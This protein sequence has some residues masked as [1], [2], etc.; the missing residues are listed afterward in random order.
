MADKC[1]KFI[2]HAVERETDVLE[3]FNADYKKGAF[4]ADQPEFRARVAAMLGWSYA[5]AMPAA[6]TST[7]VLEDAP[8]GRVKIRLV[9]S[10]LGAKTD[11]ERAKRVDRMIRDG[12]MLL[13][14]DIKGCF[15][16][17]ETAARAYYSAPVVSKIQELLDK[18]FP[19]IDEYDYAGLDAAQDEHDQRHRGDAGAQATAAY[20]AIAPPRSWP[21][22]KQGFKAFCQELG[23][24]C[25]AMQST[26]V[27]ASSSSSSSSSASGPPAKRARA[28]ESE[29]FETVE[30]VD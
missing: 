8:S 21:Q 16:S 17:P 5:P 3:Y 28:S 29:A 25:A 18:H 24:F 7:P 2:A 4:V 6:S 15:A 9:V 19:R 27:V 22:M 23:D 20:V 1:L 14:V 13:H 26:D 10:L 11:D 12:E 30:E